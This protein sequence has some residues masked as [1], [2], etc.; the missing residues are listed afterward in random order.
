VFGRFGVNM[1][2]KRPIFNQGLTAPQE[3]N[4][5]QRRIFLEKI[6][7][8]LSGQSKPQSK[9]RHPFNQIRA[10]AKIGIHAGLPGTCVGV[11]FSFGNFIVD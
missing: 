3:G 5:E 10:P 7:R 2:G 11:N 9:N 4:H 1:S 8:Y 6:S